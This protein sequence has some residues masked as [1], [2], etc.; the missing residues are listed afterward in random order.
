VCV[1]G[2]LRYV[3]SRHLRANARWREQETAFYL[4]RLKKDGAMSNLADR[5]ETLLYEARDGVAYITLN[6]PEALN[7]F[8]STMMREVKDLWRSLR[9][10]DDVRCAV[11][12]GAG[13]RAFCV[14]IDRNADD[15]YVVFEKSTLYGTSNNYM[16]DDPG[17]D[18]GPKANDLWKPV[19]C[20]VN[21]M[22]CGGAFYMIAESDIVVAADHATFFDPHVTYGQAAVYEPMMLRQYIS[23]G[24]VL[25]M[26]LLGARER[27]SAQTALQIGLVTEVVPGADLAATAA[28]LGESIASVDP[29]VIAGTL[30]AVWAAND[31][32]RLGAIAMA[33][34]ILSTSIDKEVMKAGNEAFEGQPRIKPRIR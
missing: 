1:W 33:P 27:V 3:P 30:R 21:G 14:G 13:E 31:L 6:R 9:V 29:H 18:L 24:N 8:D 12:T 20:A 19:V 34:S 17:R 23:L 22:A 5:Y 7:A 28:W 25:R 4:G 10:D 11:L 15:T 16:Y 32:G 26:A 2:N